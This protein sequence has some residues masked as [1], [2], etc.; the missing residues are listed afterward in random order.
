[1]NV[2][3]NRCKNGD[4]GGD[5]GE[6]EKNIWNQDL[7]YIRNKLLNQSTWFHFNYKGHSEEDMKFTVLEQSKSSDPVYRKEREKYLIQ[8]FNYFFRGLNRAPE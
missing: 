2:K 3:K 5:I 4:T 6:T 1:M 7:G 8:E